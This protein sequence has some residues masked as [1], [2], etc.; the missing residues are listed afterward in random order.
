M[1]EIAV[2]PGPGCVRESQ[3]PAGSGRVFLIRAKQRLIL[4][5][6]LSSSKL[7]LGW[8]ERE[9]L[10]LSEFCDCRDLHM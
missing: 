4:S 2:E 5:F 6:W 1:P 10:L 3:I 9:D 7:Y 8:V